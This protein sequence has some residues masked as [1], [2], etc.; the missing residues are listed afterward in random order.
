MKNFVLA[1]R[2]IGKVL[3]VSAVSAM[4]FQIAGGGLAGA[5]VKPHGVAASVSSGSYGCYF[6]AYPYGLERSSIGHISISGMH[7]QT[8]GSSGSF[9]FNRTSAVLKMTSG[10][11]AGRVAHYT[12]SPK[13]AIIFSRKENQKPNGSARI[14]IS[15]T[16]CYFGFK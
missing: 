3:L 2:H 11:L 14:D 5:S 6:N 8:L 7:Y 12:T 16:W 4:A 1:R 15:D 10:P 13:K 9:S